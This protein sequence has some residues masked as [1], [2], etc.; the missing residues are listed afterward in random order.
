MDDFGAALEAVK[1][2]CKMAVLT[3]GANGSVVSAA[4][5]NFMVDS[6]PIE[7]LV[8]TTGAG[9]AYAAGFLFGLSQGEDMARCARIGNIIAAEV[10]QHMGARSDRSLKDL[11]ALKLGHA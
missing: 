3:R 1:E 7:Q 6:E 11:I 9:D 4:G 10:V 8:D 5:K 2:H